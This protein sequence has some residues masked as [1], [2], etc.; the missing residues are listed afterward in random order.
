MSEMIWKFP[1]DG[2]NELLDG[3][4]NRV[5][6]LMPMGSRILTLQIHD[7]E[8]M[9]WAIFD[10]RKLD[11]PIRE[12][13]FQ[14]FGTGQEIEHVPNKRRNYIGSYQKPPYIWHLFEEVPY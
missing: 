12:R 2:W 14:I 11:Y 4:I 7:G 13:Y 6:L 5:K 10:K 8:P 9:I 1:L 3:N